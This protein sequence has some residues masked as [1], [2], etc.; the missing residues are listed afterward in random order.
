MYAVVRVCVCGGWRVCVCGGACV[1]TCA[2]VGDTAVL[3]C[4]RDFLRTPAYSR[5]VLNAQERLK[6]LTR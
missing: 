5:D 3:F 4:L 6:R 1:V 2:E